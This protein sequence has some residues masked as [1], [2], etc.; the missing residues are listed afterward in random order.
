[1]LTEFP[2]IRKSLAVIRYNPSI[3]D[4]GKWG[5]NRISEVGKDGIRD[6]GT[7][8]HESAHALDY[9]RSNGPD[10]DYSERVVEQAR[11]N[12]HYRKN[13]KD[14]KN[15]WTR[16]TG[17]V[18]GSEEPSEEKFAYAIETAKGGVEIDIANEIYRIAR[19][20]L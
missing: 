13:S 17:V 16:I 12:L 18:N 19:E 10:Y 6:Y 20:G 11:K 2:E 4:Y 7:G 8:I 1:M 3:K 15:A 9:V 5:P 14:Y